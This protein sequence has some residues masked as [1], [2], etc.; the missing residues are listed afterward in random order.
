MS[1]VRRTNEEGCRASVLQRP[2]CFSHHSQ[3]KLNPS[4]PTT[5]SWNCNPSG[6]ARQKKDLPSLLVAGCCD[7][8]GGD[9][10]SGQVVE[11]GLDV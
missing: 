10:R 3:H 2:P 8:I 11:E 7:G 4:P 5:N 6:T 1:C 9:D